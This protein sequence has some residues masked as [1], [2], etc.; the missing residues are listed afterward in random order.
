[1]HGSGGEEAAEGSCLPS[2]TPSPPPPPC[3]SSPPRSAPGERLESKRSGAD[4]GGPA[5]E[6]VTGLLRGPAR[7]GCRELTYRLAFMACGTQ[8]LDTKSGM[9][10]IRA[11]DDQTPDEVLAQFSTEQQEELERMRRDDGVYEKLSHSVAPNVFGHVDVKR[12]VLLMLLGGVQKTTR[13]GIKLRGDINVAIVGDPAC[14]KSQLLK[15][16]AAFLPRAVYTSGKS[17]SAAGLTASVVKVRAGGALGG[18]WLPGGQRRPGSST[19]AAAG[20]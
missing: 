7:T 18:G 15:Y 13:E 20:R 8:P 11:D 10:N 9:V 16:V 6:G 3:P 2:L 17:S 4:G 5:A 14:A 12:A 19:A 1:M